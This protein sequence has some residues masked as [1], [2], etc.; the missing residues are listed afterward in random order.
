VVC[1]LTVRTLKPGTFEQFREAFTPDGDPQNMPAGWVGFNMI[2]NTENPDEVICF[3]FFDG[4]VDELRRDADESGYDEQL[5]AVA[6]FVE[7]VGTD[8]LFEIVEDVTPTPNT[9]G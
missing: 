3:G 6:P 2:R 7:S 4:T 9:T 8:G 5:K 1:A